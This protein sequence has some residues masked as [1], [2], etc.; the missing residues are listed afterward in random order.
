[1]FELGPTLDVAIGVVFIFVL[2]SSLLS[3]IFEA[4]ASILGLRSKAL[5]N[6]VVSLIEDLPQTTKT[7]R[8]FWDKLVGLFGSQMRIR[9]EIVTAAV[10]A[11]AAKSGAAT[12]EAKRS[13]AEKIKAAVKETL[14][15]TVYDHPLIGGLSVKN[16]PSYVPAASFAAALLFV[17]RDGMS[18]GLA[19]QA[20]QGIAAIGDTNPTLCKALTTI[21]QEAQ[22]DWDKLKT[23]VETW[24]DA[25]MDRLSGDYKRFQQICVFTMGLLVA[26]S[27]NVDAVRIVRQLYS[28]PGLRAAMTKNA[29][30]FLQAKGSSGVQSTSDQAVAAQITAIGKAQSQLL[31]GAIPVG[32]TTIPKIGRQYINLADVLAWWPNVAGWFITAL[33]GML[34]AP[35]WFNTLQ[36]LVNLRGTGPKPK[37]GVQAATDARAAGEAA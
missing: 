16:K 18:G 19:S 13:E 28:E 8:G 21:A 26:V 20:E 14:S 12:P 3:V 22:G 17:L 4:I 15:K 37:T 5:E 27:C 25:S 1:M 10:V 7:E 30:D 9:R 2:F 32:W 6:S 11:E 29:G 23:G 33:A 35:F 36:K 31:A 24:F 34:G